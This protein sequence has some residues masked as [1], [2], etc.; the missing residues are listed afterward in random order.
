MDYATQRPESAGR[1]I[2]RMPTRRSVSR[3]SGAPEVGPMHSGRTIREEVS[4]GFG[5]P[6]R[7]RTPAYASPR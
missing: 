4:E 7:I 1:E 6:V 3:E 5:R 2:N